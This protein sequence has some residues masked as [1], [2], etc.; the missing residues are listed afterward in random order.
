MHNTF[1][2]KGFSGGIPGMDCPSVDGELFY[3]FTFPH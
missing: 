2:I 3:A 1:K